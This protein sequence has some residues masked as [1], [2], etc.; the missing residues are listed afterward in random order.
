MTRYKHQSRISQ[1]TKKG[2]GSNFFSRLSLVLVSGRLGS[3]SMQLAVVFF[4]WYDYDWQI[5][6]HRVPSAPTSSSKSFTEEGYS[7]LLGAI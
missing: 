7:M 5:M 6:N 3:N 1:C 2:H 4:L